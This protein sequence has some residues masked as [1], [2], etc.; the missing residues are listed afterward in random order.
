MHFLKYDCGSISKAVRGVY[1]TSGH[2]YKGS[3]WYKKSDY[4][5]MLAGQ[6][7]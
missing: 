6:S 4:E 7:N 3:D 1:F 2:H 5:E